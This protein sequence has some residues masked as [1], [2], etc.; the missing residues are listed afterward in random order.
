[1]GMVVRG[2]RLKLHLIVIDRL[3]DK[4]DVVM[5]MDAIIRLGVITVSEAIVRFSEVGTRCAVNPQQ[6]SDGYL[7]IVISRKI[8]CTH[9][10]RERFLSCVRWL[11]VDSG[12]ELEGRFLQ[13]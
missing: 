6:E 12:V 10:H 1:M 2:T 13:C 8:C 3:V 5:G 4:I 7:H 9:H 11:T